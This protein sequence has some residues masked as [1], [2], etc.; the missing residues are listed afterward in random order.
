MKTI[1]VAT[2][3]STRSDRAIRRGLLLAREAG[4]TL[5]L[6]HVVDGDRPAY[7][8]VP[9]TQAA[10]KTLAEAAQTIRMIDGVAC[11]HRVVTAD[12]F[13][14]IL[15]ATAEMAADLLVIGPHRRQILRDAFIGTTAERVIRDSAVPV[16]MA[17]GMPVGPYRKVL[18]ASDL[19]AC[20]VEAVTALVRL[21][22]AAEAPVILFRAVD[23]PEVALMMR[24][25]TTVEEI[26]HHVATREAAADDELRAFAATLAL[27]PA[28]S[29]ARIAEGSTA[30]TILK[31]AETAGADLVVIGTRGQTG[32]A[33]FLLGSVA[34][35]VLRSSPVDVLVVPPPEPAA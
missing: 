2:D 32:L 10:E 14:G 35:A 6:L 3:F 20:S 34:E 31:E 17:N 1:V 33:R 8:V 15:S 22:L 29:V 11:E 18:A 23:V 25:S 28:N 24:A 19:S 13:E 9:D 30:A 12:A 26:R 7:L 4:A 5:W 16:L 21:Q 27:K